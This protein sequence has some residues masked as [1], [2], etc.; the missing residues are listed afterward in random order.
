MYFLYPIVFTLEV[1]QAKSLEFPAVSICNFNR[2]RQNLFTVVGTP[3]LFSERRGLFYCNKVNDSERNEIKKS[4]QQYL[5]EYYEM[6]EERRLMN[7]H[8]PS[9]LKQ[10]CFFHERSCPQNR[11]TYF[12]NLRYGNCITFNKHNK[13][14]EA[15]TVSDV[16]HNTGLILEINL[17]SMLYHLSTEAIGARV[18]I[19]HPNE[20]PSPEDQGFNASPGTEISVSL[21]Q[22][23]M[24]RLPTPFRDHCVDYERRQGSSASNQ[25]DCVRTCIQTENFA[26]C[27]CIDQT[28]NVMTNLTHCSLT[29]QTQ[30][31]CLDDVLETLSNY[32]P[33]CCCPQPYPFLWFTMLELEIPKP[34]T[35]SGTKYNHCVASVPSE[36]P[37]TVGEIINSPD[38]TDPYAQLKTKIISLWGERK[39]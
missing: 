20:T 39:T 1:E 16:G 25:K 33:F 14:N 31:C 22:S 18:V 30:M 2:L 38:K 19:H 37:M 11:F 15:L 4:M 12:Q 10:K 27:N 8:N 7:G 5:V 24:Y 32:G 26:K 6:N 29:N 28:L 3:L 17:Q 36:I 13:E 35:T 23:I 9:T 21:R 34:I